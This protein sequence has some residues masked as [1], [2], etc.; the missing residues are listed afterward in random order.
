MIGMIL[1]LLLL[2]LSGCLATVRVR[3]HGL[4][5]QLRTTEVSTK[6]LKHKLISAQISP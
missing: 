3:R 4:P 5:L 1:L 2:L 6:Y